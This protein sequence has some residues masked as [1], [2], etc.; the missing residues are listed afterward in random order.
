[1]GKPKVIFY[2]I[3]KTGGIT[4]NQIIAKNYEHVYNIYSQDQLTKFLNLTEDQREEIDCLAGHIGFGLHSCFKNKPTN[5]MF[6]Q[7]AG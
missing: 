4:F 1:M 6:H 2:H 3:P 5:I 7:I